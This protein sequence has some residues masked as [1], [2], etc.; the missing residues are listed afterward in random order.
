MVVIAAVAVVTLASCKKDY[1]CT[2][3][4]TEIE[5]GSTSVFTSTYQIEEA[6]KKQA[7]IACNE[8]T[9]KYVE[10]QDSYT[11]KCDLTK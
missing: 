10:G 1:S 9:I 7:E 8:A 11:V 3:T 5:D 6:S 2:C 4:E